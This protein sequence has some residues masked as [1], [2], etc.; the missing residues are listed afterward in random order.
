MKN[1]TRTSL[2]QRLFTS[3][4]G[5]EMD[6]GGNVM[7]RKGIG[8]IL[9]AVCLVFAFSAMPAEAA[10]KPKPEN[11]AQRC[12][13]GKDNDDDGLIDVA[14]PD[15]DPFTGGGGGE[16][17]GITVWFRDDVTGGD[18]LLSDDAGAPI[19]HPN[20]TL[21]VRSRCYSDGEQKVKAFIDDGP[22]GAI[23]LELLKS[24]RGIRLN[25]DFNDN[26][27][28]NVLANGCN[29]IPAELKNFSSVVQTWHVTARAYHVD[30]SP[31]LIPVTAPP[32]TEDYRLRMRF[33]RL[34]GRD[35][36]VELG[37]EPP[38]HDVSTRC[39]TDQKPGQSVQVTRTAIDE[40]EVTAKP[41][42]PADPNPYNARVCSIKQGGNKTPVLVARLRMTFQYTAQLK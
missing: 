7:E 8:V 21:G 17:E 32:T 24:P 33:P 1:W 4:G 42:P 11:T 15:C 20:C 2:T 27:C 38:P 19:T 26:D 41:P 34:D 10:P 3:Q 13:D 6:P 25:L 22:P 35:W 31:Q 30:D 16:Q 18:N 12:S 36:I 28:L 14:D 39:D 29:S 9:M 5:N 40:W 37:S 23:R